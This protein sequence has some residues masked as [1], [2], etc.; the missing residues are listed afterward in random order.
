MNCQGQTKFT[1]AKQLFIQNHL[2]HNI[3]GILLCQETRV[4]NDIFNNCEFILNNYNIIKNNA[5]N[6]YG[7]LIL[8]KNTFQISDVAFDTEGS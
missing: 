4:D 7:M 2:K 5:E 3:I 1:L 6:E 8:I